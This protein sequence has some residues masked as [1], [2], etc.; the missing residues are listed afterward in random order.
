MNF[1]AP[2]SNADWPKR[3]RFGGFDDAVNVFPLSYLF[4]LIGFNGHRTSPETLC[5]AAE[6]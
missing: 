2:A 1:I 5:A 3:A 6:F 4:R